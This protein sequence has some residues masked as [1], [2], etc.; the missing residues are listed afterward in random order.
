MN[1]LQFEYTQSYLSDIIKDQK[2]Y[3][4]IEQN[5]SFFCKEIKVLISSND[6]IEKL[7]TLFNNKIIQHLDIWTGF[8]SFPDRADHIGFYISSNKTTFTL[9]GNEDFI[10]TY[11]K[12]ILD[13]F[14]IVNSYIDWVYQED[15][16]S[17]NTPL[18]IDLLPVNSMYPFLN[19]ES[20]NSFYQRYLDS[21][22]NVL[23]LIGKP[24]TGK[25]LDPS[26]EICI[27]VSD[28]IYNKLIDL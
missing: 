16:S 24:G 12:F 14:T 11:E 27:A 8:I 7:K 5:T 6:F 4:L 23:L 28:E 17:V 13:N 1:K 20:L 10:T 19:G 3:N 26:E 2:L 15:G 18:N 22:A 25:C 21:N 9:Y